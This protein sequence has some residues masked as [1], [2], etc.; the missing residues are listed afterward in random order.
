LI[1]SQSV[2]GQ[3]HCELAELKDV[4]QIDFDANYETIDTI[5]NETKYNCKHQCDQNN[6]CIYGNL[7]K[8]GKKCRKWLVLG[9]DGYLFVEGKYRRDKKV[10]WWQYN[11][12]CKTLFKDGKAKRTVCI[13]LM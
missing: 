10:G 8:A 12:H 11:G 5:I 4:N 6:V 1:N 3:S 2:F 13:S 9:K 7:N